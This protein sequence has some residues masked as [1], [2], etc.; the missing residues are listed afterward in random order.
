MNVSMQC[1]ISGAVLHLCYTVGTRA[2]HTLW[3][4][5]RR[6][7]HLAERDRMYLGRADVLSAVCRGLPL[8]VEIHL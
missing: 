6:L 3:H 8:V 7:R 5:V 1:N 2:V 4:S